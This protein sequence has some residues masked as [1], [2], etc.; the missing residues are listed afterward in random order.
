MRS[1]D[2]LNAHL[3]EIRRLND[4]VAL[5]GWDQQTGMPS[6]ASE[7]RGAQV[8]LLSRIIHGMWTDGRVAEALD[9]LSAQGSTDPVHVATLRNVRRDLARRVRVTADLVERLASAEASAFSAWIAAK[10]AGD[11]ASFAPSLATLLDLRKEEAL[12]VDADRSPYDTMIDAH[13]PGVDAANVA[14]MFGR[15]RPGLMALLEALKGGTPPAALGMTMPVAEQRAVHQGLLGALGYDLARGRLDASEHPFS[16]SVGLDDVRITTH[17]YEEDLLHGLGSTI[18]EVGHA[19]YEQGLPNHL[20]DGV[21][22]H[23]GMGMHESQSRF[24][25]NTIGRSR[26]FCRFVAPRF[27]NP[28]LTADRLW[29]AQHRVSA[30]PIRVSADE[31]TYNLH[32]LVRFELEAA[33]VGGRLAIADLPGAWNDAYRATLGVHVRNDTEGVLQDVHWAAGAFGYFPSYTLGN[34]YAASLA[35]GM[36]RDL[37]TLWQEVEKGQFDGIR[38]WLHQRV[39]QVGHAMDAPDIVKAAVGPR[40]HVQDLLDALSERY[41]AAYGLA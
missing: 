19:L 4:V 36:A 6:G 22:R 29:A 18:H 17:L 14:A 1:F 28:T 9:H 10:P 11:F 32:I 27:G 39:H 38:E 33:L 8:G 40:D 37:P 3:R 34:L 30:G 26:A 12:A 23:A 20:G 13:D 41:K 31:V 5:L 21:A 16:T 25:E 24:W 2:D 15:L 7:D 35:V